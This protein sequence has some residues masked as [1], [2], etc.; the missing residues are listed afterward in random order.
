M[1]KGSLQAAWDKRI[2]KSLELNE[3]LGAKADQVTGRKD[4][5]V[6]FIADFAGTML[7]AGANAFAAEGIWLASYATSDRVVR[8]IPDQNKGPFA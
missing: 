6:A 1:K 5:T 2:A 8:R 4:V 7:Q 3:R